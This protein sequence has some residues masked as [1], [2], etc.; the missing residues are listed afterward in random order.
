MFHMYTDY[1][2]SLHDLIPLV[3]PPC[4]LLS[5]DDAAHLSVTIH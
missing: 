2:F 3:Q 5:I 4:P 1:T